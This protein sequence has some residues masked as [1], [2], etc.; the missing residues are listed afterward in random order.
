M[1][2][3]IVGDASNFHVTLAEEFRALGHS[4]TIMSEGCRWM[5]TARDIDITRRP[6]LAGALRYGA[7]LL[8]LLPKMRGWDVVYIFSLNFLDLRPE[9]LL[10]VFRYLRRHNRHVVYSMLNTDYYYVKA[11]LDCETYRYSD[12]RIGSAPSPYATLLPAKEHEW[13]T[14]AMRRLAEG[15]AEGIDMLIACLWEY[16]EAYRKVIPDKLRYGGIPIK[17]SGIDRHIIEEEPAQVRF[18]LG[19]HRDRM[20]LKGTDRILEALKNVV[21]RHPDKAEMELVSNVPYREYIERLNSSHVMLDQL[22]S[23]TPAT[24]ALL[25]MARGMVAVSG[26]EPEYYDFI[27]E[28]ENRPIINISPLDGGDIE[29]K[30]EWIVANKSRLPELS[31]RS[32][33]FVAKHNDSR[34]VAQRH[35]KYLSEIVKP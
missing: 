17:T 19:Y 2:I 32:V 11:C 1:N 22:Y 20:A 21:A 18:F 13:T 26:A 33:E 30:L 10:A 12:F 34:V 31:R 9:K 4:V 27:G 7:R 24:N 14:D 29:Q 28:Q 35:L 25:G 16:H 5:D 6:G 15:V 8:S 3:L 23:Y